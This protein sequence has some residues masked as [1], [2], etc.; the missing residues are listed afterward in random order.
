VLAGIHLRRH[1]DEAAVEAG[2]EAVE[3]IWQSGR[4]H[5][6]IGLAL[7]RLGRNEEARTALERAAAMLPKDPG[8]W[9]VLAVLEEAREGSEG[10]FVRDACR[11]RARY[12]DAAE[13]P[14]AARPSHLDGVFNHR[15]VQAMHHRLHDDAA[16][17]AQLLVQGKEF[18]FRGFGGLCGAATRVSKAM[19]RTKHMH[20]GI[21]RVKR[22]SQL[23]LRRRRHVGLVG[24]IWHG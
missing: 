9:R 11:E 13:A 17:D 15:V 19:R 18:L 8:P 2:M 3:R 14:T 23:G 10:G 20:M 4:S 24:E 7:A 1:E 6:I 16:G 12:L 21:A 22:Q 5:F